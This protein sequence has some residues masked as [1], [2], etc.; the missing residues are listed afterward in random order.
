MKAYLDYLDAMTQQL[1]EESQQL[2]Q[3]NRGDEANFAKIKSNIYQVCKTVYLSLS[4]VTP[5][6]QFEQTYLNKLRQLSDTWQAAYDKAKA[7]DDVQ[8]LVIEESKLKT[9][10]KIKLKFLELRRKQHEGSGC[11]QAL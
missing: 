9:V 6:E 5:Q 8:K 10:Q 11:N 4:R 2:Q 3:E 7:H 1:N